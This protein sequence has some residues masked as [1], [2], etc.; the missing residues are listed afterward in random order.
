MLY[1]KV[2]GRNFTF[3]NYNERRAIMAHQNEGKG[4]K[5]DILQRKLRAGI[6]GGGQG[7]FIGM[8]WVEVI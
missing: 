7:S 4:I 5:Q 8:M 3:R 2:S 6:V 1:N